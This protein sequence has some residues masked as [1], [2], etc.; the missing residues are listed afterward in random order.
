MKATFEIAL[1]E[2]L[3]HKLYDL[4]FWVPTNL[5][6]LLYEICSI[7]WYLSELEQV[8][9]ACEL[10]YLLNVMSGSVINGIV[11]ANMVLMLNIP[12]ASQVGEKVVN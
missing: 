6:V 5:T 2:S 11:I 10:M 9:A 12:K 4:Y 3:D 1:L 7:R 8:N